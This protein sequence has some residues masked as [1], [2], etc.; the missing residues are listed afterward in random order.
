VG[1]R[2]WVWHLA[3]QAGLQGRVFND[4][5][6]VTIEIF[7]ARAALDEF[8]SELGQPPPAARNSQSAKRSDSDAGGRHIHH[9]AER[10]CR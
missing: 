10:A 9:R 6:G 8:V 2:P 4:G 1:F 3:Q 5:Q 7:G